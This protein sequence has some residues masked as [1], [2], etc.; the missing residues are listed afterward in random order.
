MAG[1]AG[2][3]GFRGVCW[4]S[5]CRP[6]LGRAKSGLC[7]ATA[8]R[9]LGYGYTSL[10]PVDTRSR[11]YLGSG[12]WAGRPIPWQRRDVDAGSALAFWSTTGDSRAVARS[13]G[14]GEG[15]QAGERG[16]PNSPGV[17]PCAGGGRHLSAGHDPG[18][19]GPAGRSPPSRGPRAA[20]AS[21]AGAQHSPGAAAPRAPDTPSAE[22]PAARTP[23]E[24][25][26]GP[27]G[28]AKPARLLE[29]YYFQR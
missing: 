18:G 4:A 15:D 9:G 13:P 1:P 8:C 24:C 11:R 25:P 6:S 3:R 23:G 12:T 2:P 14:N 21:R 22:A 27:P 29:I 17:T 5:G 26:P 10:P 16:E 7:R 19:K 20:A 28:T